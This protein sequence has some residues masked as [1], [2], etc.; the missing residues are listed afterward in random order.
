MA[1]IVATSDV[2]TTAETAL[3]TRST[4]PVTLAPLTPDVR[5]VANASCLPFR[6]PRYEETSVDLKSSV[7]APRAA[8]FVAFRFLTPPRYEATDASLSL[9]I[10][11]TL[12]SRT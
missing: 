8:G 5:R 9:T 12:P 6:Y 4:R 1:A 2:G 11:P 10:T 7:L 3:S